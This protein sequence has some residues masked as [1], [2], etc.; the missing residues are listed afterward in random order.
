MSAAVV[1]AKGSRSSPTLGDNVDEIVGKTAPHARSQE[2]GPRDLLQEAAHVANL[3]FAHSNEDARVEVHDA[4]R[5]LYDIQLSPAHSTAAEHQFDP[6]LMA[7]RAELEQAWIA[8]E[9]AKVSPPPLSAGEVARVIRTT[10]AEHLFR[11]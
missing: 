1:I 7:V 10:W 3:A 5:R 8:H 6:M 11:P 4:L 2:R 9:L